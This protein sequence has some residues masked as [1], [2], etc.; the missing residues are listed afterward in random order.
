[1]Q[2]LFPLLLGAV[3]GSA[4]AP[5]VVVA[6]HHVP[7]G[8]RSSLPNKVAR[9]TTTGAP[10]LGFV[11]GPGPL[12]LRAIV[13]TASTAHLSDP[14]CV[15]ENAKRVY[16]PP[17]QH[18]ALIEQDGPFAVWRMA[19]PIP[20]NPRESLMPINGTMPRPDLVAFSPRGEAAMLYSRTTNR[21][22]VIGGL[23][24]KPFISS[25]LLTTEIGDVSKFAL[26]D[27]GKVLVALSGE[28]DLV[29]FFHSG[30][31]QPLPAAYKPVAWSFMPKAHDLVI[32][33]SVQNMV[34]LLS[35][36]G[37]AAPV[38]H[39]LAQDIPADLV[40]VTKSGE[41]V[42]LADSRSG[43]IWAI[44]PKTMMPH[45]LVSGR[46]IDWLSLL[47]DG[48]TTLLSISPTLS[49]FQCPPL[50]DF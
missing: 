11:P 7:P 16:L 30:R 23:P 5:T 9:A 46:R 17:R 12:D 35:D 29:S 27:D 49:L 40:A 6:P 44:E 20:G 4:Q 39:I 50:A 24:A 26:S 48:H 43:T 31:W 13:G 47:R 22:Q 25:E 38:V 36:V 14:I 2:L 8:D 15:P 42:I 37:E 32:S 41:A 33:D 18:Y 45:Q 10:L 34:V 28:S 1:M 3:L 21:L 19:S